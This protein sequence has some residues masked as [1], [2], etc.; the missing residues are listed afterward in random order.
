MSLPITTFLYTAFLACDDAALGAGR[1]QQN[2]FRCRHSKMM[3]DEEYITADA[4]NQERSVPSELIRRRLLS[5]FALTLCAIANKS[6]ASDEQT[7]IEC[8]NGNI[9]MESAVPG[10]YQQQ[11]FD[12]P[13]RS[14]ILEVR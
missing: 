2:S 9:V 12:L 11:C 5:T 13:Q 8:K 1:H 6:C 7:L 14:F 10:A 4:T 3:K